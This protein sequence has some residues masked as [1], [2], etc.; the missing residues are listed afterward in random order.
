MVRFDILAGISL[1]ENHYALWLTPPPDCFAGLSELIA[2]V[3]Q[4]YDTPCFAPHVSLFGGI[5]APPDEVARRA[6]EVAA[7]CASPVL[8]MGEVMC[9]AMYFRRVYA[10]VLRTDE[11][12]ALRAESERRFADVLG[13]KA[14][15]S[16][17]YE[18]HLS[19]AYGDLSV[20]QCADLKAR[21]DNLGLP[22][23]QYTADAIDVV[24]LSGEPSQWKIAHRCA[25]GS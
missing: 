7:A 17:E 5:V 8:Q 13:D 4:Y 10:C 9:G 18:P 23:A 1:N 11:L 22:C 15:A 14:N 21:I 20:Q 24:C 19:L 2:T 6:Q 16:Q 12:S 25:F 3:G